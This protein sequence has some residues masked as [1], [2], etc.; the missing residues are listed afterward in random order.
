ME[1][2][3]TFLLYDTPITVAGLLDPGI[4]TA[5]DVP[6]GRTLRLFLPANSADEFQLSQLRHLRL[7]LR[8]LS[9]RPLARLAMPRLAGNLAIL[10]PMAMYLPPLSMP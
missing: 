1:T 10:K 5:P 8:R 4:G 7:Y 6:G 3:A 2:P 9:R